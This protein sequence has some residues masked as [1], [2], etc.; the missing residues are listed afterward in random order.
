MTSATWSPVLMN[1]ESMKKMYGNMILQS[2]PGN[3]KQTLQEVPA[4]DPPCFRQVDTY[5]LG[6]AMMVPSIKMTGGN[7]ILKTASHFRVLLFAKEPLLRLTLMQL[8]T[9]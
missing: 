1:Q 3:A 9:C 6:S 8:I 2:I 7:S 4:T 5:G